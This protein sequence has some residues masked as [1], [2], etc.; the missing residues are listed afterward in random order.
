MPK[1]KHSL[2]QDKQ[3]LAREHENKSIHLAK[4]LEK[5]EKY[6]HITHTI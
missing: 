4:A 3:D 6:V 2:G 1:L 5:W